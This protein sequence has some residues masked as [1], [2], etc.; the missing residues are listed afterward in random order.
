MTAVCGLALMVA[1]ATGASWLG[2]TTDG[3]VAGPDG[4]NA[5]SGRSADGAGPLQQ[6]DAARAD[7]APGPSDASDSGEAE[8]PVTGSPECVSYCNTILAGCVPTTPQFGTMNACLRVCALY[9]HGTDPGE[10]AD[11][12]LCRAQMA[13]SCA[14]APRD[15]CHHAGPYGYGACGAMCGNFCRIAMTWCAGSPS[16]APFTSAAVCQTECESWAWASDPDGIAA[17]KATGPTSG[18]T[19]E[20]REY[21]LIKSVD[22][23]A[24]RDV[25]CPRAASNSV[26]C[27]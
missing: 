4:A 10:S 27:R 5:D 12:L 18:N 25:Y 15:H 21:Q 6:A 26:P 20:C 22:S 8:A 24:N 17:F 19:L 13:N 2:C 23:Y 7:S 3:S 14:T 9:P 1:L 11:S 16:G